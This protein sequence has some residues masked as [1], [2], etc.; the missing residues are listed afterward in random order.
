MVRAV[1]EAIGPLPL[2]AKIGDFPPDERGEALLRSLVSA[3]AQYVQA[4]SAVNAVPAPVSTAAGEQALP[5]A[6][7]AM[8]GV[9]GAA[10][11][12]TG[13]DVVRRLDRIRREQ[14][15]EY[16]IVGV[17]GMM[18]PTD[19][20]AYREAGADA[21]QGATGPMWNHALAVEIARNA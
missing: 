7:R 21:V 18:S 16:A 5:G 20:L 2:F 10:L 12:A 15:Y 13:L 8:A 3:T 1:R 14:G 9:A 11:R 6:G 4:Y 19:Y 17:G